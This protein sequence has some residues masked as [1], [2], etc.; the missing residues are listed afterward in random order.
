MGE[1]SRGEKE[2]QQKFAQSFTEFKLSLARFGGHRD[3]LIARRF[4]P[5]KVPKS[6][7]GFFNHEV[8]KSQ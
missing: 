2:I 3:N 4:A 1:N 5:G 8:A 6:D 7:R